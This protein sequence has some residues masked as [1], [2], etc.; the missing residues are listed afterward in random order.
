MKKLIAMTLALLLPAIAPVKPA[1]AGVI[2]H[3][4]VIAMENKDA[5]A[6]YGNKQQAPYINKT[7][8]SLAARAKN[9]RDIL[10]LTVRSQPHYI[11]MQAGRRNFADHTFTNNDPP[12]AVN[13]TK[14]HAHL[15]YQLQFSAW[16]TVPTWMSYQQSMNATTGD[17][18]VND[19]YPYGAKHNPFVYFQDIAG[20]PPDMNNAYCAAHHKPLSELA[21]DLDANTVA[22]YVFVTPDM[23][24]DMHDR[25]NS[26]SRIRAGDRWLEKNMP[27]LMAW[28]DANQGVIFII[29]D[30]GKKTRRLPFFA[31]GPGVKKG[32]AT[33]VELDHR[34]YVKT[35]SEI[36][37]VPVLQ[38]VAGSNSFKSM[39]M[40]GAYP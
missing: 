12:S 33:D 11:L 9:F 37:E 6:I 3:V 28:A 22:N 34:S 18:P 7:L 31:L 23:C 20:N 27:K 17:C 13:S 10:G 24:H 21:T 36:F 19:V 5:K 14:S 40:A 26:T 38:T 32:F 30:E 4:F 25:C 1:M 39:F 8:M 35:L 2:K 16:A 29:W 15:I